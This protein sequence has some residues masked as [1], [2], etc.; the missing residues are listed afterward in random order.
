MRGSEPGLA[1]AEGELPPMRPP[2]RIV[3][4]RDSWGI[5]RM[6]LELGSPLIPRRL[7]LEVL[8]RK[9]STALMCCPRDPFGQVPNSPA[10][11]PQ[12]L[13]AQIQPSWPVEVLEFPLTASFALG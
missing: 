12:R 4:P 8:S 9:D 2:E 10:P 3:Q 7:T 1:C 11:G 6:G 5:P 13:G